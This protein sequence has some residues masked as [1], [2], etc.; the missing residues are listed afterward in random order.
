MIRENNRL[1]SVILILECD[2]FISSERLCNKLEVE[3]YMVLRCDVRES[4]QKT[5]RFLQIADMAVFIADEEFTNSG[6][7]MNALRFC[8]GEVIHALDHKMRK[9]PV[10]IVYKDDIPDIII[11]GEKEGGIIH[12]R[13]LKDSDISENVCKAAGKAYTETHY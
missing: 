5:A 9:I 12:L 7:R 1:R 8:C 6:L 3:G 4:E 11:D 2:E 10:V 13:N